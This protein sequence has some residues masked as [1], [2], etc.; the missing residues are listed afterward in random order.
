MDVIQW[1]PLDVSSSVSVL[2]G[3]GIGHMSRGEV[4]Y[5]VHI[6]GIAPIPYPRDMG[7]IPYPLDLYL[8]TLDLY[9]T[10]PPRQTFV[11]TLPSRFTL[12]EN[13]ANCRFIPLGVCYF[14]SF[15]WYIEIH[16]ASENDTCNPDLWKIA[17]WNLSEP[18]TLNV[19]KSCNDLQ[20]V[21]CDL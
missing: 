14:R 2:G 19:Q 8:T 3:L 16:P 21:Q 4:G 15:Q 1:A 6:Q 9:P 10:P 7:H 18:H 20:H 5:R 12:K 11:K 17:Q 13:N